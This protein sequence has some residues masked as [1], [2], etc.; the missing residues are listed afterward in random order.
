ML[1]GELDRPTRDLDVVASVGVDGYASADPLPGELEQAVADVA[2]ALG[3]ESDWLNPG[4]TSLLQLG[5]PPG[6]DRRAEVRRYGGLELHIADRFDQIHF[7]LYAAVDQGPTSKHFSDL[8]SLH[9]SR[10]ELLVAARWARTHD[11]SPAF[12]DD[13][14]SALADLGIEGA[15]DG[16]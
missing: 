3:L 15:D 8:R 1:L 7:K 6:F 13:L 16:L 2:S 12:R 5:L 9:A 14:L 11:P 10:D 4:P